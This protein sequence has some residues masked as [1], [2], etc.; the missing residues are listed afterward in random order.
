MS[1]HQILVEEDRSETRENNDIMEEKPDHESRD[2]TCYGNG[3]NGNGLLISYKDEKI[4]NCVNS[5]L[6]RKSRV[7]Y[8]CMD[9]WKDYLAFGTSSGGIYLFR[10][11]TY[12][13]S[14]CTLYCMIPCDAGT[15][16]VIRFLPNMENKDLLIAMGTSRGSLVVFRVTKSTNPSDQESYYNEIYRAEAFTGNWPVKLIEFD[17]TYLEPNYIIEKIYICDNSNRIFVLEYSTI[18]CGYKLMNYMNHKPKPSLLLG[19]N[20]SRINQLSVYRSILLISTDENSSLFYEQ[21][22]KLFTIGS[23]PR[24]QGFYGSCF[25]IPGRA[26]STSRSRKNLNDYDYNQTSSLTSINS[27]TNDLLYE[28]FMCFVARPAFRLWQLNHERDVRFTHKFELRLAGKILQINRQICSNFEEDDDPEQLAQQIKSTIQI[29]PEINKNDFTPSVNHFQ[30]LLPIHTE[31]MGNL[32]LSYSTHEIYI[33]DPIQADLVVWVRQD[34]PILHV[35]CYENEIFIWTTAIRNKQQKASSPSNDTEFETNDYGFK[36]QRILLWAPYQLV[37]ELHKTQRFFSLMAFVQLCGP[38]FRQLMALPLTR[39]ESILTAEGGFLR[40]I[41]FSSWLACQSSLCNDDTPNDHQNGKKSVRFKSSS[42]WLVFGELIRKIIDESEEVKES[43]Q[44][45]ANSNLFRAMSHENRERLCREPYASLTTLQ[46]DIK[47]IHTKRVVHFDPDIVKRHQSMVNLSHELQE[48]KQEERRA[49]IIQNGN[50]HDRTMRTQSS[51]QV[52]NCELPD[53]SNGPLIDVS[54]LQPLSKTQRIKRTGILSESA[55]VVVERQKPSTKKNSETMMINDQPSTNDIPSNHQALPSRPFFSPKEM[56]ETRNRLIEQA[57]EENSSISDST[58]QESE[59]ESSM[60]SWPKNDLNSKRQIQPLLVREPPF[61]LLKAEDPLRCSN[62]RWPFDRL[63]CRSLSSGQTIQLRWMESNL[64][65]NF[66]ENIAEI[67][68]RAFNHGLWDLLLRCLAD[69][70]KLDDYVTCCM[71]LDDVRLLKLDLFIDGDNSQEQISDRILELMERKLDLIERLR[72]AGRKSEDKNQH[73]AN[74]QRS[75]LIICLN[76][77]HIQNANDSMNGD[78]GECPDSMWDD[79]EDEYS[80]TLVNL[81]EKVFMKHYQH[82]YDHIIVSYLHSIIQ[83]LLKHPKLVN[84][85]KIP[86]SFYL[87]IIGTATLIA[88]QSPISRARLIQLAGGAR[89]FYRD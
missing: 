67:E 66:D 5:A 49:T 63:H 14:P 28:P 4:N 37:L 43:Y 82:N 86:A 2:D 17:Q 12:D 80:F 72:E 83:L 25:F 73:E 89:G 3:F 34:E 88:K 58:S 10:L 60:S 7:K 24:K 26:S 62:C 75:K 11:G 30:K 33:I 53:G 47:D 13:G 29:D 45:L 9:V 42:N 39:K 48:R 18:T 15:V 59:F 44:D 76:C 19:I 32:L 16:E 65:H 8:K 23:K 85:S 52:N 55:R 1:D 70:N 22:C 46:V 79:S 81:F 84:E 20:N 68:R 87:K 71:M 54:K 56:V 6:K 36:F 21:N 78:D 40:N 57:N 64:L 38:L 41:L 35:S 61:D 69:A 50:G 51:N 77:E 27:S 74:N 31:T